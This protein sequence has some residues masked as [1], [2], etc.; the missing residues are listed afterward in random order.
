MVGKEA[1][2]SVGADYGLQLFIGSTLNLIDELRAGISFSSHSDKLSEEKTLT[3]SFYLESYFAAEVAGLTVHVGPRLAWM[4]ESRS[5][6]T[7]NGL[8]GFGAGGIAG[9]QLPLSAAVVI[10]LDAS[11]TM[12]Q[13]GAADI[14]GGPRDPDG[15]SYGSV[16]D[17]RMGL[18]TASSNRR[19]SST[20]GRE[21]S[22]VR[23]N[24]NAAY[25]GC[26]LQTRSRP[27][28]FPLD[29]GILNNSCRRVLSWFA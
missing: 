3:L 22:S 1:F 23:R 17:L 28:T 19:R 2:E 29:G 12:F 25:A 7:S 4:D 8:R 18:C 14:E 26:L 15:H 27:A 13:F 6:F 5:I 16:Y 24:G 9:V 20:T 10:E 11:A 21:G